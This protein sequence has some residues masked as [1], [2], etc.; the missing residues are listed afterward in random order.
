[1]DSKATKPE[2]KSGLPGTVYSASQG[3]SAAKEK[4]NCAVCNKQVKDGVECE[5]CEHW[6]HAPCVHMSK[7]TMNALE[8]DKSL[9]WYCEGCRN[10]A[11]AMWKKL[12]ERQDELEDKMKSIV[13]EMEGLKKDTNAKQHKMDQELGTMKKEI[14]GMKEAFE[15]VKKVNSGNEVK[16]DDALEA[17]WVT[18]KEEVS[19]LESRL[20]TKFVEI[21]KDVETLEI[22]KKRTNIIFHGVEES[23]DAAGDVEKVRE[24]LSKGLNLDCERHMGEMYRIGMKK[25]DKVRPIRLVVKTLE[26]KIEIIKR[27][28][29]LK[30]VSEFNKIYISPDLTR[31]QQLEDKELRDKL[32]S[33]RKDDHTGARIIIKGGKIVMEKADGQRSILFEPKKKL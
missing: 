32:K 14:K 18:V 7:S 27:A 26:G 11:V 15:E 28:K 24:I 33:F 6:F 25:E 13:K 8:E 20:T 2:Q 12:K 22:E 23:D 3:S 31:K 19:G 4:E 10:G 1:M 9:H 17:K 29:Q 16:I 21:K 30:D 5:I